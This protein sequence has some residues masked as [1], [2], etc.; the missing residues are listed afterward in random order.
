MGLELLGNY[1]SVL[2]TIAVLLAVEAAS[3]SGNV[4]LSAVAASLP[5]GVPLAL[6]LVACKP[7]TSQATLAEFSESVVRG[8]AGTLAFAV[9]MVL[10]VRAGFG[11]VAML[12][13]G[14]AAWFV[15]WCSLSFL[16]APHAGKARL[17]ELEATFKTSWRAA[18]GLC[19]KEEEHVQAVWRVASAQ[20]VHAVCAER[21][22]EGLQDRLYLNER[23]LE[24]NTSNRELTFQDLEGRE[25][26]RLPAEGQVT[27]DPELPFKAMIHLSHLDHYPGG[28]AN[29]LPAA[30]GDFR[31]VVDEG[32]FIDRP[33]IV[34]GNRSVLIPAA[35]T[36]GDYNFSCGEGR[37]LIDNAT[38]YRPSTGGAAKTSSW[39]NLR[40]WSSSNKHPTL[41]AMFGASEAR[42]AKHA[43]HTPEDV[44]CAEH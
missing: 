8:A 14:Y 2:V 20:I 40:V 3:R 4:Q 27:L 9:A 17:S 23:I 41:C 1:G 5:T 10:V 7:E 43:V 26:W 13:C 15:T 25:L 37:Q 6:F 32:L 11:M 19:Q 21:S 24:L 44:G 33:E 16:M 30:G 36:C 28:V 38:W 29:P 18:D 22:I 35:A 31:L 39:K 12:V 34:E 42:V